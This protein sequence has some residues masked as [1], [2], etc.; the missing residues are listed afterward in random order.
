M[1][2]NLFKRRMHFGH[3]K[4]LVCNSG[5]SEII[6]FIDGKYRLHLKKFKYH[7]QNFNNIS[8]L[9]IALC[10]CANIIY[11]SCIITKLVK[12]KHVHAL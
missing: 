6:R 5:C 1:Q 2:Q 7:K 10:P 9:K 3:F 4:L 8:N 12:K 11:Y